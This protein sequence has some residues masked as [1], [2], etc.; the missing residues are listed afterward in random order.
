MDQFSPAIAE[1]IHA[2][3]QALTDEKSSTEIT[4]HR[5]GSK[6]FTVLKLSDRKDIRYKVTC[7][8]EYSLINGEY[9]SIRDIR[10]RIDD[11]AYNDLKKF[12]YGPSDTSY[13]RCMTCYSNKN[14]TMS[15]A[16]NETLYEDS[17][18]FCGS[19][20]C[21]S[22]WEFIDIIEGYIV[23][24]SDHKCVLGQITSEIVTNA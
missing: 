4:L 1:C 16:L 13:R 8:D 20:T 14:N 22:K 5:Y 9:R 19:R 12:H 10:K 11:A 24:A 18:A 3:Q 15:V 23:R 2:L 6:P 21:S 7:S 17:C